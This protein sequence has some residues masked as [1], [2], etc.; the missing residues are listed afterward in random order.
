MHPFHCLIL[1]KPEQASLSLQSC[2]LSI[3]FFY[4]IYDVS[5]S[6][7]DFLIVAFDLN[8][9]DFLINWM[10]LIHQFVSFEALVSLI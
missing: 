6:S 5:D 1:H 3:L 8:I 10:I 2:I 7:L 4:I 9:P